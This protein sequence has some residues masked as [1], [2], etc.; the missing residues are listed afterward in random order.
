MTV[1]SGLARPTA[2]LAVYAVLSVLI[3]VP[4]LSFLAMSFFSVDG[5]T[6]VRTPTMVNFHRAFTDPVMM[7]V[8]GRTVLL[9]V[10]I[11]L[12]T[13]LIAY[14]VAVFINGLQGGA[15]YVLLTLV[16]APLILSYVMKIYAFR[17]ILGG[18]GLLNRMLLATGLIDTPSN[19]FVFNLNAVFL[20]LVVLLAPFA[21]LP[22]LLSLEKIPAS[23]SEA[24][25]DLSAGRWT[26]F[27]TVTL[28]L[29]RP[30]I[31]TA[32]SF[33]FIMAMG[34]FVTPQMVGGPNGFTF[35][36]II[37]SQFGLAFNWPFGAALGVLMAA[38]IVVVL[39][40]AMRLGRI[41]GGA[42]R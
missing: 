26:T 24:A 32:V 17:S 18:N 39:A 38:V 16:T 33:T 31:A 1:L 6:I 2:S 27:R 13:T 30:G 42:G 29:S 11:A 34:D 22:I 41:P 12:V 28:P 40:L 15:R 3:V 36:R 4:F 19:F 25:A 10:G 14:P 37:Y 20:V 5:V 23:L 9:C 7:T 21:I 8:F 35:G